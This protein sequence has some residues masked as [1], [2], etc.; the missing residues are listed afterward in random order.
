MAISQ[1]IS[2][3]LLHLLLPLAYVSLSQSSHQLICEVGTGN[4]GSV[5]GISPLPASL[6]KLLI[7]GGTVVNAH[8]QER[9]DVYVGDEVTVLDATGRYVMPGGIDPHTHLDAEFMGTVAVDD[10]FSGQAA[11]LAGGTTM[12]I[13]FVHPVN[14][15]LMSGFEAYEKK[16]SKSCMDYGFHMVIRHWDESVSKEMEI[17]VK[18]KGKLLN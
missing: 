11:A 7:K 5:G 17:M 16:A 1:I 12:H 3:F 18:E 9:A 15:S 13:D 14:G 8:R 6:S 2:L 4:G 10:F